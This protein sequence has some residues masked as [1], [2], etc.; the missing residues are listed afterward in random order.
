MTKAAES[1]VRF[2]G[3]QPIF[4]VEDMKA[5]LQFYVDAMHVEDPDGN[6]VRF[7]SEPK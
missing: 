3:S 2:E 7:A 5:S 1:R 6:V 4:P